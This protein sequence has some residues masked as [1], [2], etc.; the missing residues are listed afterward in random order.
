MSLQCPPTVKMHKT[1]EVTLD[2][3]RTCRGVII[4]SWPGAPCPLYK[5]SLN[6]FGY[7]LLHPHYS[8]DRFYPSFLASSLPS[9][10]DISSG[11]NETCMILS[12]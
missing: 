3:L 1:A 12:S 10:L 5:G 2:L 8:G 4:I 6:R 11:F 9:S 7:A